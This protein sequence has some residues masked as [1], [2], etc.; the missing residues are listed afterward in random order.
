MLQNIILDANRIF[1]GDAIPSH[2]LKDDYVGTAKSVFAVCLPKTHEEVK[3]L[4]TYANEHNLSIIARGA[5]TGLSGAT[6]PIHENELIIDVSLM[7]TIHGLDTNTMTLTV[8]PGVTLEEIQQFVE[9][10]GFFYPPDPGSKN[11]TIGG[12]VATNAGGM[13][14]VKYGVT[15]DYV[16]S[17]RVVLA[18]GRDLTLGSLN[19]KSSSGYDLKNLFIGSEGTLGITTLIQL[20]VIPLPKYK[21]SYVLAF[22]NLFDSMRCVNS[23]LKSGVSPTALE[24][25]ERDMISL[26]E[27]ETGLNFPTEKGQSFLLMTLDGDSMEHI[28]KRA[29]IV[30]QLTTEHGAADF[31]VLSDEALERRVW[32]LRDK[33][34]T[35]VVN[36]TEQVTMDE[37]VPI[38]HIATLYE[39]TKQLEL[40]HGLKLMSFGHAGDGNLHTCVL[41][42]N[43]TS[44]T[45]WHAKR[46]TVLS[47][48]YAKISELGGLPS[49]E[50]GIGVIKKTYFKKM[51]DPVYLDL[52]HSIKSTLDPNNRFNPDK[53]I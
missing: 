21:R 11:S 22:N 29:S 31:L 45:E 2:Y 12:N 27:K 33:L 18:D 26:S 4:V 43:I 23:I 14:A 6:A 41:R 50:H 5:G 3:A 49:A 32:H 19:V 24:F 17:L 34:L 8:E 40:E 38:H 15:R 16:R 37:T 51:M 36:Y 9:S 35:A 42:G 30:K 20:K 7:N 28:D 52:I 13:R 46:D 1:Q 25:F 44:T 47:L 10:K 53:L 48:L 39:Y